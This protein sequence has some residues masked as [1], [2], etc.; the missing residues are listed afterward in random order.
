MRVSNI[1]DMFF[2]HIFD[3]FLTLK[4]QSIALFFL[5]L[6]K[7][8]KKVKKFLCGNKLATNTVN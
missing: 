1:D 5:F 3:I 7:N 2:S 4:P 8:I 6:K